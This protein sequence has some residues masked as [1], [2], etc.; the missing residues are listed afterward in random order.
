MSHNIG[1]PRRRSAG[2]TL[3]ELLVVIGIIAVLVAILLP[4]L[5]RA[6]EQSKQVACLSNLRELGNAFTMYLNNNKGYFPRPAADVQPEDW[7]Y[8]QQ[9][10]RD[11]SDSA[12]APYIGNK[13]TNPNYFR[14]PSDPNVLNRNYQYSYSANYMILRLDNSYAGAYAAGLTNNTM[15]IT[16]IRNAS[17]KILLIDESSATIDDGCWAWQQNNGEGAN[18]LSN[19]H[20]R[21]QESP[22]NLSAGRGNVNFCDGHAEWIQRIDTFNP[23]YY[24]PTM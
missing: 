11:L 7:I 23:Y 24:D 6:R 3:V 1:H 9:P 5:N 13:P 22:T 2:F 21:K 17:N 4:S 15:K 20:D 14:C 19:R 8:W 18:M 12:I 16:Q 10:T